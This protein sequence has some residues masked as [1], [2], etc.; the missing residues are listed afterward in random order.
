MKIKEY[1]VDSIDFYSEFLDLY[2]VE[3]AFYGN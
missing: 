2:N 3:I 1:L